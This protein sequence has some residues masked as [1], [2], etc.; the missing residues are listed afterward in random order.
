ME[1]FIAT[2]DNYEI[3]LNRRYDAKLE[4]FL[5]IQTNSKSSFDLMHYAFNYGYMQG[6]KAA[7]AEM[8]KKKGVNKNEN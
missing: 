3:K 5:A 4:N 1:N 7:L 2:L 8:K 6:N